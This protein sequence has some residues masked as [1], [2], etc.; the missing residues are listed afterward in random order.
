MYLIQEV[1]VSDDIIERKFCCD[2]SVCKGACCWKGD[3]GA[4][5]DE[6]E[7]VII[8][9]I[10]EQIKPYLSDESLALLDKNGYHTWYKD[11]DTAG[12]VLHPDGACVFMTKVD[13]IAKCGIETAYEVGDIDYQKPIS[14]HLYPIRISKN[15]EVNFEAI[16]YS[17]WDICSPARKKGMA[18]DIGL[19]AFLKESVTRKYGHEFYNELLAAFEKFGQSG[20]D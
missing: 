10:I 2:L 20:H 17:Q 11:I 1:L 8:D 16:N 9:E 12:T 6:G 3:Y 15:K 19:V 5:L 18:E 13:G 14:C 4:P 7:I